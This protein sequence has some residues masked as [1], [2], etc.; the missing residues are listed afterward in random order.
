MVD[1][2]YFIIAPQNLNLELKAYFNQPL[3]Q[4]TI[5]Y[6][7]NNEFI[8]W[9]MGCGEYEFVM[10]RVHQLTVIEK[11]T[12]NEILCGNLDK[13]PVFPKTESEFYNMED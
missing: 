8:T 11:R 1:V 13:M 12:V 10:N 4:E 3:N 6:L 2:E 5:D 9:T 7:Y